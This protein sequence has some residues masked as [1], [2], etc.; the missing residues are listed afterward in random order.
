MVHL[1]RFTV[2][3]ALALLVVLGTTRAEEAGSWQLE[4]ERWYVVEL[5]G[6]RDLLALRCDLGPLDPHGPRHRAYMR[7]S[8]DSR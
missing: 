3:W 5:A 6:A 2:L 4:D 8:R 7:S 1:R